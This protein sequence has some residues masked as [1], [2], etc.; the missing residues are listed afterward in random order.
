MSGL[1]V[2]RLKV[3][4]LRQELQ[5]RGL[6]TRG[7][8]ADLAQRLQEALDAEMLNDEAGGDE[9]RPASKAYGLRPSPRPGI[10]PSVRWSTR[11]TPRPRSRR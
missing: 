8:K 3:A 7:L 5:E 6:E 4:E 1:D 9:A 10:R 2:K 11:P